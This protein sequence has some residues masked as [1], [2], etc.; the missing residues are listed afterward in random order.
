[1]V[2]KIRSAGRDT[3]ATRDG[4]RE[5]LFRSFTPG[6]GLGA[7]GLP[8]LAGL[9]WG[10]GVVGYWSWCRKSCGRREGEDWSVG[11]ALWVFAHWSWRR[12]WEKRVMVIDWTIV[13]TRR[14]CVWRSSVTLVVDEGIADLDGLRV[15]VVVEITRG[16]LVGH[17]EVFHVVVKRHGRSREM[18]RRERIVSRRGR[19]RDSGSE[20]EGGRV[21]RVSLSSKAEAQSLDLIV[22]RLVVHA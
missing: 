9:G 17:L 20:L 12:V 19:Y 4:A 10:L 11:H 5:G 15:G 16:H 7:A 14:V 6:L 2:G 3:W 13:G 1:M 21:V 18:G 22:H 8:G